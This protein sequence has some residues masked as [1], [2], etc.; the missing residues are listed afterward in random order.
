MTPRATNPSLVMPNG[1][2]RDGFFYP[3][4]TQI[5]DFFAHQCIFLIICLF[6]NK[7]PEV[8]EY[9]KMQFHMMTLFDVLGKIAL[10][11]IGKI[12]FSIQG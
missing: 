8:P 11:L 5:T 3:T 10:V 1:D 6:Q 7:F 4:L 2:P 12:R 9:A